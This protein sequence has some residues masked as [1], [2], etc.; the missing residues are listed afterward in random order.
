MID[1]LKEVKEEVV[2][3]E[4]AQ[5]QDDITEIKK[6][7]EELVKLNKTKDNEVKEMFNKLTKVSITQE[8]PVKEVDPIEELD[9]INRPTEYIDKLEQLDKEQNLKYTC[10]ILNTIL[11]D[12]I[13]NFVELNPANYDVLISKYSK[14][15]IGD[16]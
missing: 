3:Q 1:E 10:N 8:E 15:I 11:K 12:K 2:A 6:Q 13:D 7:V 5:G 4:Q 9:K 16:I 14:K